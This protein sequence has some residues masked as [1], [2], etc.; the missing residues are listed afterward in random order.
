MRKRNRQ[1]I[2]C[3]CLGLCVGV[4]KEKKT[5]R[6]RLIK[7]FANFSLFFFFFHGKSWSFPATFKLSR[8]LLFW[9]FS[10]AT[11]QGWVF[12][13]PLALRT[14]YLVGKN[15]LARL[16]RHFPWL[17]N[18]IDISRY[19]TFSTPQSDFSAA[20]PSTLKSFGCNLLTRTRKEKN[21]WS[22]L[23]VFLSYQQEKNCFRFSNFR[24]FCAL[25]DGCGWSAFFFVIGEGKN[26]SSPSV[27]QQSRA[28]SP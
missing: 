10:L 24:F 7:A 22:I 3:S 12:Y 9:K 15:P 6:S 26:S 11:F 18:H 1:L 8:K 23:T 20:H 25:V 21:D 19:T 28:L 4:K 14:F 2:F 13:V 27:Y 5:S 16:S 17:V